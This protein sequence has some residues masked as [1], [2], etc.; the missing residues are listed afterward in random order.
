M[1]GLQNWFETSSFKDN[2]NDQWVVVGLLQHYMGDH[3]SLMMIDNYMIT[4][5]FWWSQSTFVAWW[6]IINYCNNAYTKR[7]DK[8]DKRI[9][10]TYNCCTTMM[11]NPTYTKMK[12]WI[13]RKKIMRTYHH[14][15]TILLTQNKIMNGRKKNYGHLPQCNYRTTMMID[16]TYTN[17]TTNKRGKNHGH[18]PLHDY[19]TTTH[20][21]F[22]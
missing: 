21:R 16:S 18:L 1:T 19:Y 4:R 9:M 17:K 8:H 15:T 12:P 7:Y 20:D 5:L 11:I 2:H 3:W 22:Y 14:C 10:A 13:G 6:S